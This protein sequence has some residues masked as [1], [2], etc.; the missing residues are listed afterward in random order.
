[1][2]NTE[3]EF[4]TELRGYKRSEVDDVINELRSELIKA[5]RDRQNA[6]EELQTLKE[7]LSAIEA[8][9]GESLSPSYSGLGSRLEAILRIAEEQ[10]TRIIGQADIDAERMIGNAKLEAASILEAASRE[11]ERI[12]SDA[13]NRASNTI[14][15]ATAD[16]E[17]MVEEAT[18]EAKR[19]TAE[20]VEEAS[21]IRGAVATE[22]AKMRASAKRETEALRAE[23]KREIS[24]LK[25][26]AERELNQAR[27]VASELAKEI[28][29]ERA[30]HELTLKKIQEEAA[31]AKTNIEHEVAETTAK[32]K[33]DND[34][35]AEHLAQIA[36]Q[37]RADLEAELNARRSEAEKELLDA[38]N[39]AVDLNNRFLKEAEEQ[40]AE[41]KSRLQELRKE[42]KK[43]IAAIEE[44]NRNGK[45]DAQRD[46]DK[47]IAEA[48]ARAQEIIRLA[49]VE[50]TA[51]VAA[52]ERRLV[53]LRGE[54]DTI[55]EYVESL[56]A[57]VGATL[58]APKPMPTKK[59][60]G[61]KRS[62]SP[63][64]AVQQDSAAS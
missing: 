22:S 26:V 20:A 61:S 23:A 5:S 59:A 6:L 54:R 27:T 41:T 57:I 31:L 46:A 12:T 19:I 25:V 10:S 35:Q 34:K 7:H 1:M 18:Q 53:E 37:A 39:K 45:V 44:A 16:S 21:A 13:T 40:L 2:T 4:T 17:R 15:G 3:Q 38:H 43:L 14:D 58:A 48:E 51:R 30:S 60:S 47:T 36:H 42:H 52:A 50:A 24:E 9:T 29:A 62:K 32:L 55:A 49:D 63:V 28:E 56:R 33:Y 8:S 11:A 64:E